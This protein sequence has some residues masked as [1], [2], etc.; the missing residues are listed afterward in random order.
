MLV[1]H[2]IK[3]DLKGQKGTHLDK[4]FLDIFFLF[5]NSMNNNIIMSQFVRN[6]FHRRNFHVKGKTLYLIQYIYMYTV[7]FTKTF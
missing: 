6:E 2:W 5:S 7:L 4:H 1:F 3:Y